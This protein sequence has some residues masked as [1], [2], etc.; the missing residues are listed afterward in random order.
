MLYAAPLMDTTADGD[1]AIAIWAVALI[2]LWMVCILD[3]P[4]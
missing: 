2:L 1:I 3:R 4:E